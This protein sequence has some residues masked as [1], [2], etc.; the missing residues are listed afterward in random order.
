MAL[1]PDEFRKLFAENSLVE[2]KESISQKKVS[3]AV[4]AFSNATGGVIQIG[5]AD[6]GRIVGR[7]L[8]PSNEVQIHQIFQTIINPGRY[9]LS[10]LVVG[11][12]TVIVISVEQRHEGFAQLPNGQILV[13]R[14]KSNVGLFGQDLVQ[15]I[16]DR[17]LTRFEAVPQPIALSDADPQL[18][19]EI[20]RAHGWGE[21]S[22]I[23]ERFI[24]AGL[25]EGGDR[26]VVHLTV[27]GA[28]YLLGDASHWL[29]KAHV[30]V[31]RFPGTE[32]EGFDKRTEII[33]PLHRQVETATQN[34]V[35][36]LGVD[37]VVIGSYRYE[38]PKLPT[39]VIREAIANAVAHR[40]YETNT[41]P[42][43]VS[44][45]KDA[46]IIQSPG[47]LPEPVTEQNIRE[48]QSARNPD[49]IRILR[50]L[51][52]AEDAGLGVD[53]MQDAM[54]AEMLETPRF[55]NVDYAVRVTLPLTGTVHPRE[56]AWVRELERRGEIATPDRVVLV[57]AA[58]GEVLTN[59]AVRSILSVDSVEA[60]QVLQR[61]CDNGFLQRTGERG[62][63]LYRLAQGLNVPAGLRLTR[64]ELKDVVCSHA[65]AGRQI[66][67]TTVRGVTSLPREEVKGLLREL[68]E[69]GRLVL[70]G[71]KR[72]AHYKTPEAAASEQLELDE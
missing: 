5:V 60:R 20:A 50:R 10:E 55:Q 51:N 59:A 26:G 11:D 70:I 22:E 66:T 44:V 42:I 64:S 32:S 29:G 40:S 23:E 62:G 27:A 72:G 9:S 48:T 15:F 25:C 30:E 16:G 52:L 34:V 12:K 33:G 56:R 71:E 18:V 13:R 47:G 65:V 37:Q 57:H 17:A 1:D 7:R 45:Y 68:V 28:M 36:E 19:T 67:N 61:L 38:L 21:S 49:M 14:G 4:V 35:A 63:T 31:F 3:E 46:V 54:R 2:W 58:R 8:D 24:E 43:R 53:R 41:V 39:I 6:D 69:E